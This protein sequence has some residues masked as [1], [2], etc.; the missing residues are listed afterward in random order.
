MSLQQLKDILVGRREV[1]VARRTPAGPV[2]IVTGRLEGE[3]DGVLLVAAG[4]V[5]H[6][7][8][9][10]PDLVVTGGGRW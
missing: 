9:L 10:H 7:I 3:R 2:E 6:R 4:E 5:L 1:T 8:H